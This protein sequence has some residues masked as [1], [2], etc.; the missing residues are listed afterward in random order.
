MSPNKPT[1]RLIHE[2]S[3]Y[4]L[5]HANNPVDWFPWG[6]EAFKKA[7]KENKPVLLSVGY[8]ACHW[9]HVMAH[10]SF[11]DEAIARI[12]N[13]H[14]INIKVDREE[15]PDLDQIYQ[16]AVQ[17]FIKRAGGWPLTIFMTPEKVPFYGGTYFPPEDR[18]NLPGFPK[19][20]K[21]LAEAYRD[22]PDGITAAV[23]DV[24][25]AFEKLRKNQERRPTKAVDPE[26]L[27][28]SV[29]IFVQSFDTKYGGFGG[30]PKFPSVPALDLFL[31]YY[32]QSQEKQYLERVRYSLGQ[33]ARGGVYDQL[34]GG[35]HRYSVDAAWQVPHF[36][37]MLYDNA[38][39]A[40]LYFSTFQATGE[41]FYKVIGI[42]ILNYV[43]REMC[44]S[45]GGFYSAQDADIEGGEGLSYLWTPEEIKELLGEA[46][47]SFFC[48][49][50][51]VT[52]AGNFEGRNILHLTKPLD[53]LAREMGMS[54]ESALETIRVS[55]EKLLQA[56]DKRPKPFR[57]EKI[58]TSWSSLM[59][60]AFVAGYQVTRN[61]VYLDAAKKG[62]DFIFSHL[63]VSGRLLHTCKDGIGKLTAYLDDYSFF[64]RALLDLYEASAN[65]HY[66]GEALTFSDVLLE[67]FRDE[68]K[69]G[70][71]FTPVDHEV[72]IDR[73][74]PCYDQSIPSGNA[75]AA[76]NFQTL[77]YLTGEQRYFEEAKKALESFTTEMEAQ[78]FGTGN[79]IA[80]ASFYL[81]RPKEIHVVGD[82][83][84]P[85][86]EAL[87]SEIYKLYLPNKV[88]SFNEEGRPN[89]MDGEWKMLDGKPTV[90]I[91]EHFSCSRPLTV[92]DEIRA[93]LLS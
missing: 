43:L 90:Y 72:L 37:K 60:S 33:M 16:L 54:E 91:C 88:L 83:K 27:K 76:Q 45:E 36:E 47:A 73:S 39:L 12:M 38:Q 41:D 71:Y 58:I 48:R 9:C 11:E 7:K 15:R 29:E 80:A 4:L 10:E 87:L 28:K 50:Y 79:L 18:H 75:V 53:C 65:T 70:F 5:Q 63:T 64:I 23:E 46:D 3:P 20:L 61:S 57:D 34:G 2:T 22:K 62:V 92:L 42:E 30:A 59:I 26:L 32:H 49:H 51:K 74:K 17:F 55:K 52:E 24:R 19:V 86:T 67:Q 69:G 25:K 13:D 68:A 78:P 89:G 40:T 77:F 21:S 35:F 85:E 56:R 8:S 6:K 1:N 82:R 93:S 81:L 66:L 31:R 84:Q 44:D 14:F